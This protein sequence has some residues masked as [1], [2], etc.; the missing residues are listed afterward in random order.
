MI[1]EH[2]RLEVLGHSVTPALRKSQLA[3]KDLSQ[4]LMLIVIFVNYVNS[5]CSSSLALCSFLFIGTCCLTSFI[6][7]I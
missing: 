3:R 7:L 5:E 1:F 6:A 4:Y 2:W